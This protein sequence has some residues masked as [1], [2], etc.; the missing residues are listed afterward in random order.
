MKKILHSDKGSILN[1]LKNWQ[2]F[3]RQPVTEPLGPRHAAENYRG[4]HLNDMEKCI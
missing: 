2:F 1:P 3:S 4:F